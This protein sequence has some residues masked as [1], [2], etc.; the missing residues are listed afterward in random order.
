MLFQI[1]P[2]EL[3]SSR[4]S[5]PHAEEDLPDVELAQIGHLGFRVDYSHLH[6]RDEPRRSESDEPGCFSDFG[7]RPEQ[8]QRPVPMS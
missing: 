4:S 5:T 6:L 8:R 7:F 2:D 1:G 3:E